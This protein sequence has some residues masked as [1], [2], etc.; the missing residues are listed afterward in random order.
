MVQKEDCFE[1]SDADAPIKRVRDL[2]KENG[3][4]EPVE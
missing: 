3:I 1:I 4:Y 2:E